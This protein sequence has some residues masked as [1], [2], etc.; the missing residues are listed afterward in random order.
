MSTTHNAKTLYVKYF[1]EYGQIPDKPEYF[2]AFCKKY[3]VRLRYKDCRQLFENPPIR[4]NRNLHSSEPLTDNS[5]SADEDEE[6]AV[7]HPEAEELK[8]HTDDHDPDNHNH[9]PDNISHHSHD[10]SQH[11][12]PHKHSQS[13]SPATPS[14]ISF[15]SR[16]TITKKNSSSSSSSSP[17]KQKEPNFQLLNNA[18]KI[19]ITESAI[20]FDNDTNYLS[21]EILVDRMIPL[22]DNMNI[23]SYHRDMNELQ[24]NR[25]SLWRDGIF[26]CL[27][28]ITL[29]DGIIDIH[30]FGIWY[31]RFLALLFWLGIIVTSVL[32][33]H[34]YK[35]PPFYP[36]YRDSEAEYRPKFDTTAVEYVKGWNIRGKYSED[37]E[38]ENSLGIKLFYIEMFGGLSDSKCGYVDINVRRIVDKSVDILQDLLKYGRNK[39]IRLRIYHVL[40]FRNYESHNK[41][42]EILRQKKEESVMKKRAEQMWHIEYSQEVES[43]LL[44]NTTHFMENGEW[45]LWNGWNECCAN[46]KMSYIWYIIGFGFCYR[47]YHDCCIQTKIYDCIKEVTL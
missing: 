25:C 43:R 28:W 32:C 34:Y 46:R 13:P 37:D 40:R 2:V 4:T 38:D 31:F 7:H 23:M 14:P 36:L 29:L 24:I 45:N 22:N 5:N 9:S 44:M 35:S 42:T 47:L 41:F 1:E 18:K 27:Y 21:P 10:S 3:D 19:T 16:T 30:S 17:K 20:D 15:G 33:H 12:H 8:Y 26:M 11:T 39:L 6:T